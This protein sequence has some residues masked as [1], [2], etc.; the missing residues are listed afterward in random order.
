MAVKFVVCSTLVENSDEDGIDSEESGGPW[1]DVESDESGDDS[2]VCD[3][4]ESR[5]LRDLR[6]GRKEAEEHGDQLDEPE[7]DE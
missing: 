1:F 4:T 2:D 5:G 7:E 6:R 3:P